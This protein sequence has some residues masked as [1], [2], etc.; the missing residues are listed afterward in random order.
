MEVPDG[1]RVGSLKTF[2]RPCFPARGSLFSEGLFILSG[3]FVGSQIVGTGV[4]PDWSPVVRL[5]G[6]RA[7][8]PVTPPDPSPVFG[9]IRYGVLRTVLPCGHF[10]LHGGHLSRRGTIVGVSLSMVRF[11]VPIGTLTRIIFTAI[12]PCSASAV[13]PPPTYCLYLRTCASRGQSPAVEDG[14]GSDRPSSTFPAP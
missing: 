1:R 13:L 4:K 7:P 5:G 12:W 6:G 10:Q 8:L 14:S 2:F 11:W 3:A 9:R